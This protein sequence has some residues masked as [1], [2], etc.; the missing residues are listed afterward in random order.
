[1]GD[2]A[3]QS[4]TTSTSLLLRLRHDDA[5]AWE[6]FNSF[7]LPLV[8]RWCHRLQLA[9]RE[10]I[11]QQCAERVRAA[12]GR[13]ERM[14]HGSFRAWLRAIVENL[15]KDF[16]RDKESIEPTMLDEVLAR[17][18][19]PSKEELGEDKQLQYC[20]VEKMVLL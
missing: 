17:V 10:E 19:Q 4:G 2:M 6:R 12:I 3:I 1:M 16:Y 18:A 20:L 11:A 7:Y 8:Q 9:D 5:E 14:R 15:L 13:F